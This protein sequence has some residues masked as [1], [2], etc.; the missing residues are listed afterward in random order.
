MWKNNWKDLFVWFWLSLRALS[1][2]I[3]LRSSI[4]SFPVRLLKFLLYISFFLLP[5]VFC[6]G[7]NTNC[8]RWSDIDV[9]IL[10]KMGPSGL[11]VEKMLSSRVFDFVLIWVGDVIWVSKDDDYIW[12][13]NWA[14][15]VSVVYFKRS[16][17]KSPITMMCLFFSHR[18]F[19]L[20]EFKACVCYFLS[21][22]Y[23]FIKW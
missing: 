8:A 18:N 19:S 15:L 1:W 10:P 7:N 5:L 11:S 6:T 12:S 16:T 9:I 3:L 23:F 21:S 14:V 2:S 17:L 20:R 22:F 13:R 4:N